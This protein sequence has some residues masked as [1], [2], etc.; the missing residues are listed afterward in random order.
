MLEEVLNDEPAWHSTS[1]DAEGW[2]ASHRP[3]A[4]M[5]ELGDRG[6]KARGRK[7]DESA[8][9]KL[10]QLATTALERGSGKAPPPLI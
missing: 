4:N 10:E 7:R 5:A 9:D 3:G 8:G 2:C 6:G 1:L